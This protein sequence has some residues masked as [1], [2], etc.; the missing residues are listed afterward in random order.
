MES[1]TCKEDNL[2]RNSNFDKDLLLAFPDEIIEEIM[3]FLSYSDLNN[4]REGGRR[5]RDCSVRV[6]KNKQFSKFIT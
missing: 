5:L 4:W 2:K 6:L 3:S 1:I